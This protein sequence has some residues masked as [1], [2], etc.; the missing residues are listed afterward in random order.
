MPARLPDDDT[1]DGL[2]Q[3]AMTRRCDLVPALLLFIVFA[4]PV[5]ETAIPVISGVVMQFVVTPL[6]ATFHGLAR[7]T[8]ALKTKFAAAFCGGKLNFGHN[9]DEEKG[10]ESY[11]CSVGTHQS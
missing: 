7:C 11:L 1:L 3:S 2:V 9:L 10:E 6:L 4:L 8:K 5:A